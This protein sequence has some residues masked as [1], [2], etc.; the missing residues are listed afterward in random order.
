MVHRGGIGAPFRE[1]ARIFAWIRSDGGFNLIDGRVTLSGLAGGAEALSL[2]SLLNVAYAVFT[3]G[4]SMEQRAAIDQMLNS[5]ESGAPANAI[6][7]E[8]DEEAVIRQNRE[9]LKAWG[10]LGVPVTT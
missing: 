7:R 1:A 10:A 4:M 6:P 2:R 8:N 9:A 3:D 5:T